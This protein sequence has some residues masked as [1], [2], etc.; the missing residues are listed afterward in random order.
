MEKKPIE[1]LKNHMKI[2]QDVRSPT[3]QTIVPAGTAINNEVL[4]LLKRQG[5][6]EVVIEDLP[7]AEKNEQIMDQFH[8]I[9]QR[10]ED[11]FHEFGEDK[12]M[13]SL[14]CLAKDYLKLKARKKKQ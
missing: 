6:K 5:I 7:V 4:Y 2:G 14:A 11:K 12:D 3:G 1:E 10:I 13:Q 8:Q 9:D